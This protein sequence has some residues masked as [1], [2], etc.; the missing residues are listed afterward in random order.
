MTSAFPRT[1]QRGRPHRMTHA[2]ELIFETPVTTA[3]YLAAPKSSSADARRRNVPGQ[4]SGQGS[5][6]TW[7][8]LQD[9]ERLKSAPQPAVAPIARPLLQKTPGNPG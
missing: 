9:D 7:R 1:I 2:S 8:H 3:Q 4:R 6:S 5:D